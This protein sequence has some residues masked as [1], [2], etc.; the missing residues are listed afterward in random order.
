[1]VG[2]I[3]N[4]YE[5][6]KFYGIRTFFGLQKNAFKAE[7]DWVSNMFRLECAVEEIPAFRDIAFY[8]HFILKKQ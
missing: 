4:L 2:Y 8:H 1:M 6:Q 5:I 7:A 3:A